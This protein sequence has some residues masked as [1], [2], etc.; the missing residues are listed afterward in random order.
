MYNNIVTQLPLELKYKILSFLPFRTLL[1]LQFNNK[2]Y[3]EITRFIHKKYW[4][5]CID[6]LLLDKPSSIYIKG[7]LYAYNL[8]ENLE[9]FCLSDHLKGFVG[10]M[11]I[12]KYRQRR[13]YYKV[14][15]T[16][17]VLQT[18]FK[19]RPDALGFRKIMPFFVN[20]PAA[21]RMYKLYTILAQEQFGHID[22]KK[23]RHYKFHCNDPTYYAQTRWNLIEL[24]QYKK[25][26]SKCKKCEFY[27]TQLYNVYPFMM[28]TT[29]PINVETD[30]IILSSRHVLANTT[31]TWIIILNNSIVGL[32]VFCHVK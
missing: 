4:N 1:G 5:P 22:L 19:F 13:N 23:L 14:K 15:F 28:F 3:W 32:A 21:H 2:L 25:Q 24:Y 6:W 29:Q 16:S 20:H 8:L 18:T 26:L 9:N 7:K 10:V 11:T 27:G 30:D 17:A 12:E 31:I